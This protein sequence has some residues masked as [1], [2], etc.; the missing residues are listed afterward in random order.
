[1]V[2]LKEHFFGWRCSPESFGHSGYAGMS[3]AWADPSH[4]LAV[5]FIYN[6]YIDAETS[7]RFRRETLSAAVYESLLGLSRRGLGAEPNEPY[8]AE[9]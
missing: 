5:A 1:M 6:G 9:R 3:A 8:L 7:T 2:G 4:N